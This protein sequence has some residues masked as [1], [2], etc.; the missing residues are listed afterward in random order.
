MCPEN[1]FPRDWTK[2]TGQVETTLST[3]PW[4]P[5]LAG[6]PLLLEYPHG[7]FEQV[8]SRILGYT[9]LADLLAYLPEPA[10][11]RRAEYRQRIR[12]RSRTKSKS[13]LSEAGYLPHAGPAEKP[14]PIR[15]WPASGPCKAPPTRRGFGR[16]AGK[17]VD[18]SNWPKRP[19]Q[20]RAAT[21]RR[22]NTGGSVLPGLRPDGPGAE[23]RRGG[24]RRSLLRRSGKCICSAR[25]FEPD[26]RALAGHRRC[27]GSAL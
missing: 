15:P 17:I 1:E 9:V 12:E 8:T 11:A 5:K 23:I 16:A 14:A 2:A 27:I 13:A 6:L 22:S 19:G 21:R 10:A 26:A 3:S 20:S 25:A 4:L 24:R 18:R 7:C